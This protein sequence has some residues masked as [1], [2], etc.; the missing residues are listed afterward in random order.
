[1]TKISL[2]LGETKSKL[3]LSLEAVGSDLT[4]DEA[5]WTI[6]SMTSTIDNPK[7]SLSLEEKTKISLTL[8]ETK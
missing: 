1:M 8:G 2:T 5:D 7:T 6:D 3:D 4:I